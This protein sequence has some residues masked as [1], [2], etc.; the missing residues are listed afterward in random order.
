MYKLDEKMKHGGLEWDLFKKFKEWKL[1]GEQ[2]RKEAM[3]HCTKSKV[4]SCLTIN[5]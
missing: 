1:N 5:H 3:N 2:Y 4:I